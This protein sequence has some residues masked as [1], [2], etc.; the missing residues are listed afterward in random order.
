MAAASKG[1]DFKVDSIETQ[2]G[3]GPGPGVLAGDRRVRQGVLPLR[4]LQLGLVTHVRRDD[5]HPPQAHDAQ[6]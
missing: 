2:H 1:G 5:V 6:S 3:H 4:R